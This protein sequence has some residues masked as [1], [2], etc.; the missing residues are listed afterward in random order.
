MQT[1]TLGTGNYTDAT[2]TVDGDIIFAALTRMRVIDQV[3]LSGQGPGTVRLHTDGQNEALRASATRDGSI[4]AFEQNIG[5]EWEIW[6]KDI[7]TGAQQLVIRV[8]APA[9]TNATIS[10]DGARIAYTVPL[11]ATTGQGYVIERTGGVSRLVC[12]GCGLHGFLSDNRRV[13]AEVDDGHALRV[14]DTVTS[15]FEDLVTTTDGR[16]D[17]PHASGDERWLA[18]RRTIGTSGKTL[19]VP[20]TP[21]HPVSVERAQPVDEPTTT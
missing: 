3:G 18:F 10:Q 16:L 12:E 15:R 20:L 5:G 4:I 19:V 2:M 8:K 1:L 7:R 17:R 21:G 13:L 11:R 6:T 9:L 14:Y